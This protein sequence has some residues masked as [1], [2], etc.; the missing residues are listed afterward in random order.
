MNILKTMLKKIAETASFIAQHI[1]T[2]PEIGIILGTGLGELVNE[3]KIEKAI[4]YHEIPNSLF[5][6]SMATKD[7]SF[8][9]P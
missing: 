2:K 5:L 3:I 8:L 4:P 7:N 6:Q 1:S 9:A